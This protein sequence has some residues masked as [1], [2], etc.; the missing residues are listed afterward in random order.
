MHLSGK[1]TSIRDSDGALRAKVLPTIF[2][3]L[4]VVHELDGSTFPVAVLL[5]RRPP[6]ALPKTAP[7][8]HQAAIITHQM[9]CIDASQ[10]EIA[11]RNND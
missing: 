6:T 1:V 2:S 3:L 4:A 5:A 10:E 9:P 11:S 8:T 7:L